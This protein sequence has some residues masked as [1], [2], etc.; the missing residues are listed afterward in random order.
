MPSS[1][2]IGASRGITGGNLIF[3]RL[4]RF[5]GAIANCT[6]QQNLQ[7]QSTGVLSPKGQASRSISSSPYLRPI[8]R[9]QSTGVSP[10]T[11]FS[12]AV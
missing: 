7:L 10:R 9:L 11:T 8:L 6:G 3:Q 5:E 12:F 2:L 1:S 4:V